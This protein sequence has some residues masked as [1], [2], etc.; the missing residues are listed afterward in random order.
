[1]TA[2]GLPGVEN[3]A[4]AQLNWILNCQGCHQADASGSA[5]GAPNMAGVMARF[6]RVEGGREYLGRVPGVA[7]AP[8]SDDALAE[9][10]NWSLYTFD[11]DHVP[12]NFNPYT[13]DEVRRLR[14]A[15]LISE[16]ASKREELVEL[17]VHE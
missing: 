11:R 15:P 14:A 6:L 16:A 1:M 17:F 12:E 2:S 13:A 8:L 5:G 7:H 4:R 3:P 10:L 9:L